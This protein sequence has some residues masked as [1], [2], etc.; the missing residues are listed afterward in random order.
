MKPLERRLGRMEG[1]SKWG[2]A[3]ELEASDCHFMRVPEGMENDAR[4]AAATME[5]TAKNKRLCAT[6]SPAAADL[7][8]WTRVPIE[9][10]PDA[11]LNARI[12]EL[13]AVISRSEGTS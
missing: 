11:L 12:A 1:Q 4:V 10:I 8:L 9:R 13:H 7:P 3:A 2:G 6:A 5:A